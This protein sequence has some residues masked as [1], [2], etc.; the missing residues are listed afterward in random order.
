[1]NN[2]L[3]LRIGLISATVLT[4]TVTGVRSTLYFFNTSQIPLWDMAEYLW[5]SQH[6]AQLIQSG[7]G[8]GLL[9]EINSQVFHPPLLPI[10]GIPFQRT[11]HTAGFSGPFSIWICWAFLLLGIW[12][13]GRYGDR[14]LGNSLPYV[15]CAG[16]ILSAS[17]P[18][19][20][21][22]GNIF[23][24]EI[25]GTML[26]LWTIVVYLDSFNQQNLRSIRLTG[27]GIT[28]LFLCKYNYLIFLIPL[29]IAGE[30][31]RNHPLKSIRAGRCRVMIWTGTGLLISA[32]AFL[33]AFAA[34]RQD[35]IHIFG[36]T[37]S[38]RGLSNV[39]Y[40]LLLMVLFYLFGG[41][42]LLL[43]RLRRQNDKSL[44][45]HSS[46]S[47]LIHWGCIPV[48]IWVLL[49]SP[50]RI[51]AIIRF[52][53]NRDSGLTGLENAL[54]YPKTLA[55]H[56]IGQPFIMACLTAGLL[57]ALYFWMKRFRHFSIRTNVDFLDATCGLGFM[58]L[59][60]LTLHDYKLPRFLVPLIPILILSAVGGIGML[61]KTLPRGRKGWIAM[62][63]ITLGILMVSTF[64]NTT[65]QQELNASYCPKQIQPVLDQI[66]QLIPSGQPVSV[67]GTFQYLSPSLIR[68]WSVW[69]GGTGE[70]LS[71]EG[72]RLVH[73]TRFGTPVLSG[74]DSRPYC[75]EWICK[76]RFHTFITIQ[77]QDDSIFNDRDYRLWNR[78]KQSYID[79]ITNE[80]SLIHQ[81]SFSET[82]ITISAYEM[83]PLQ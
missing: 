19:L 33:A 77:V 2:R 13:L 38:V 32:F 22:F 29:L 78:W 26:F 61:M 35:E 76:S 74:S 39:L 10:L 68:L 3:L 6:M 43:S 25:P 40:V 31:S 9:L 37:V 65:L 52:S 67:I 8:L 49:P 57:T 69:H 55:S 15:A 62:S 18:L 14:F 46:T 4:A 7:Y 12:M 56:A 16:V 5:R 21:R 11:C 80:L 58:G 83:S 64:Q 34:S 24:T 59:L 60:I 70:Y 54:F 53:V 79:V 44:S 51:Y 48:L 47:S 73:K 30:W 41:T 50:N 45:V 66:V 63:V 17:S 72:P 23:M 42:G 1:M 75:L 27:I 28:L 82:G 81:Q 71:F 20:L 36:N